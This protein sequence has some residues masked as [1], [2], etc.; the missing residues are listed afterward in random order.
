MKDNNRA[1]KHST[2]LFSRYLQ[3]SLGTVMGSIIVLFAVFL[4]FL[5]SYIGAEHVEKMKLDTKLIADRVENLSASGAYA[6][7]EDSISLIL[8]NMVNIMSNSS[9]Y[10][11]DMIITDDEGKV[12]ICKDIAGPDMRRVDEDQLG[13]HWVFR[14]PKNVLRNTG[15][16]GYYTVCNLG[17][18]YNASY[19]VVGRKMNIGSES[20]KYIYAL[21]PVYGWMKPYVKELSKFFFASAIISVV[22]ISLLVYVLAYK[23]SEPL[24]EMSRLTK[25]Y[26]KGDFS[27]KVSEE[28]NDEIMELACSLNE[29]ADSLS[30]IDE[31][32]KSFVANVSHELKTPMTT[33]S[34][35]IDGIL[36]G[37]IPAEQSG[38]YLEIVSKE[39]K[40]LSRLVGTMLTLSK[41]EAGEAYLRLETTDIWKLLFEC[42]LSFEVYIEDEKIEIEG[43]EKM[44]Q[45][46]IEADEEMLFQVFYNLYDNAVKFTEPGGKIKVELEETKQEVIVFIGNTGKGIPDDEMHRI[47]ERFYKVD[48]S[49]SEHVKGVGLGL[50][51]TKNIVDLHGG[52]I[53][54]DSAP[55]PLGKGKWTTFTITLPKKQEFVE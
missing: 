38:K 36:D 30:V 31:A 8:A 16:N 17:E 21:T 51:L 22:I 37:T 53:R 50:N 19:I 49:R 3:L 43:F 29:M 2:T 14:M 48:K 6:N 11:T 26:A 24:H 27:E 42:L 54:V 33:I 44:S 45:V 20:A 13:Y 40:R 18:P 52:N 4:T 35:F 55:G 34:G 12:T 10:E 39:V 46:Y 41:I 25:K 7:D 5:A 15:E 47:F 23:L 1:K 28:G 32:R 9:S